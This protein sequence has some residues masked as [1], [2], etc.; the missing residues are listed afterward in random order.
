[1]SQ[2]TCHKCNGKFF[3]MQELSP[4]KNLKGSNYKMQAIICSSCG[5]IMSVHDWVN[6]PNM[7]QKLAEKLNININD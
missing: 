4:G 1:M 6:V 7:I 5:T 2:P 3:E